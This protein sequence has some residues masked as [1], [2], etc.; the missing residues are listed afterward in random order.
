M[1]S[2]GSSEK[3]FAKLVCTKVNYSFFLV[4]SSVDFSISSAVSKLHVRCCCLQ[5]QQVFCSKMS[6]S[7]FM[8]D[9]TS[10]ISLQLLPINSVLIL[11]FQT[12]K[13][14]PIFTYTLS[15]VKSKTEVISS[16]IFWSIGSE[17]LVFTATI[18]LDKRGQEKYLVTP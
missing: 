16:S 5:K 1:M 9:Q 17:S 14:L 4:S 8:V 7:L 3:Q 10:K 18:I 15:G 6:F 11:C 2:L 12:F 13:F